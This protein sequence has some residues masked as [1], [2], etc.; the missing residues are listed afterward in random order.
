MRTVIIL[1]HRLQTMVTP[2]FCQQGGQM[3]QEIHNEAIIHTLTLPCC[4]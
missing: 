2:G 4:T 1:H 3:C